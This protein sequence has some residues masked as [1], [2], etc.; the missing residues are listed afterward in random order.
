MNDTHGRLA[1]LQR[2]TFKICQPLEFFRF[3]IIQ[4]RSHKNDLK[5]APVSRLAADHP[6]LV[7][8]RFR[9]GR[10]R[11]PR[12]M[13]GFGRCDAVLANV[14]KTAPDWSR[15]SPDVPATI[16]ALLEGCLQKDR[17]SRIGDIAAILFV[18]RQ[19]MSAE[20]PGAVARPT[21]FWRTLA[22][23][24][25][26]A[27]LAAI[28]FAA[29]LLAGTDHDRVKEAAASELLAGKLLQAGAE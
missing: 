24:G 7:S 23:V 21:G 2:R 5:R 6:L 15:L 25:G 22:L 17:R 3:D 9:I 19:P 4:P 12:N 29:P 1:V 20:S 13:L 26:A 10:A 14:L 16:R 11:M 8:A 18:L 27:V 28:V